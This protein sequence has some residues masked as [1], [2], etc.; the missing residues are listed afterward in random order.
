MA[1]AAVEGCHPRILNGVVRSIA[2]PEECP[3]DPLH[4]AVV[5]FDRV[6]SHRIPQV[7]LRCGSSHTNS[8]LAHSGLGLERDSYRASR[9]ERPLSAYNGCVSSTDDSML[10]AGA[11]FDTTR[12]SIVL[13]A[14]RPL[15]E[16]ASRG[17]SDESSVSTADADA[18]LASLCSTYWPAVY[19]YLRRRGHR[20]E[21]ARDLTQGFFTKLLE[22]DWVDRADAERGSFR[23]FLVTALRR[24]VAGE[25]ERE[26]TLKRG[27]GVERISLGEGSER[28]EPAT[29]ST[30]ESAFD[31]AWIR[32]VLASVLQ[33][34]EAEYE[35]VGRGAR[36][37]AIE[38]YLIPGENAPPFESM[39]QEL[40]LAESSCR[41]AVFR[42]R[43]RYRDLLRG[44]I[45]Q[46]VGGLSDVDAELEGL[47][48]L[49][50][51]ADDFARNTETNT[52]AS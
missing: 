39:A 36:F 48:A 31:R 8:D 18:A 16:T 43:R 51:D 15:S 46:T 5:G 37:R 7:G 35:S 3:R 17:D 13:R 42:A 19:A 22:S 44:E 2:I 49:A 30:P 33:R 41:V 1:F 14:Q 45:A 52:P 40:D 21:E 24:Y 9:M 28:L 23:S 20:R 6:G 12:W 38:P 29:T 32:T 25:Y 11:R 27:G 47:I 26:N 10:D 4:R 34:L 50:G